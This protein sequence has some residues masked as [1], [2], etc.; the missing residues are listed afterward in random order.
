M[1]TGPLHHVS[2]AVEEVDASIAFYERALAFHPVLDTEVDDPGHV[3][4]LRLPPGTAG[5][6]VALRRERPPAAGIT[7]VHFPAAARRRAPSPTDAGAFLLAFEVVDEDIH[8]L[9]D[10]LVDS[11]DRPWTPPTR[12]PLPGGKAIDAFV[13]PDPDGCL[14]ELYHVVEEDT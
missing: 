7:L 1:T 2:I 3:A 8:A 14:V 6:A 5:R 4:Y 11:G 9:H 13:V 10:R 12:C